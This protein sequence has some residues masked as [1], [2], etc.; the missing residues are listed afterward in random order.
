MALRSCL[1]LAAC[2][3]G[4]AVYLVGLKEGLQGLGG[5]GGDQLVQLLQ[6]GDEGQVLKAGLWVAE[7][8][9]LVLPLLRA[10]GWAVWQAGW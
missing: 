3:G 4:A 5:P 6:G 7:P 8:L 9:G 10:P 1:G 2:P